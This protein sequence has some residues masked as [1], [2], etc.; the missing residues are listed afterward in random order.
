MTIRHVIGWMLLV[1]AAAALA[2]VVYTTGWL[3]LAL[4][5]VEGALLA[6]IILVLNLLCDP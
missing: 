5:G 1:S 4:F 3:G 2:R 6:A